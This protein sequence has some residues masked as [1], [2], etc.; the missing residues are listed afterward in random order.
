[1]FSNLGK[2]MTKEMFWNAIIGICDM[3]GDVG[4]TISM[5]NWEA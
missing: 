3:I 5:L 4:V 2:Q 1:M